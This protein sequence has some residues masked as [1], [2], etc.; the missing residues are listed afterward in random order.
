M[1]KKI[2]LAKRV[3]RLKKVCRLECGMP[4]SFRMKLLGTETAFD[5]LVR[6]KEL[7]R[8]GK[9]VIH[10]EIGEPDFDTPQN[11][12]EAAK[13]ALDEGWTHYGPSQGLPELRELI[14]KK[15]GELRGMEFKSEEVVITPGAKPVMSFA[16]MALV[17]D[18]DEVLY[19]NPGFPIYESMINFMGGKAI[20]LALKEENDFLPDLKELKRKLNKKTKLLIINFPHNPCGSMPDENYFRDMAEI[21]V[22]YDDLWVLSDE[23]YSRIIYDEKFISIA[24][25]PGMKEKTI[26]LDGFSKTYAMTGWRIGYGIMHPEL[27]KELARIETNINSCTTT[28]IQRACLE[29]LSGPQDEVD[30]M[31]NEFKKRRDIIFEGLNEIPGFSVKVKPKGAFYIFANVKNSGYSCKELAD[32]LLNELGVACLSGTCFGKY[33]EGFIRFSYA[34]SIENIKEALRR[35]KEFMSKKK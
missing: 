19:V 32:K 20:P 17:E 31:V 21:L 15:A 6:A 9:N 30:K 12:K 35:I 8:Q 27:A 14:A 26:I 33:G 28:F 5:V 3:K 10:L 7:E 34:N 22:K 16:I 1:A 25:F 4:L 24:S 23:V 11:I 18:G 13:K 2:K 29:A